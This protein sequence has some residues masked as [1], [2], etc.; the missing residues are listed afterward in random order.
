MKINLINFNQIMAILKL[1]SKIQLIF[2]FTLLFTSYVT[3]ENKGITMETKK[4]LIFF[5]NSNA[6]SI[7]LIYFH[8]LNIIC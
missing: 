7:E 2:K 1:F 3:I 8:L 4:V 5:F 6:Y